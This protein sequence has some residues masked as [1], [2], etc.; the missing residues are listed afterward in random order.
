[1]SA[2]TQG[3]L[4]PHPLMITL[5]IIPNTQHYHCPWFPLII[6]ITCPNIINFIHYCSDF[7]NK[8]IACG[9]IVFSGFIGFI[10]FDGQ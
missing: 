6:N 9:F 5:D 1:M 4:N 10:M 3:I 7:I 8:Q 2:Q